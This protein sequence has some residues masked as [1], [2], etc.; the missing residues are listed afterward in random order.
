MDIYR[1]C[2]ESS[3]PTIWDWSNEKVSSTILNNKYQDQPAKPQ[4]D[5]GFRCL[6]LP[7]NT[8]SHDAARLDYTKKKNKQFVRPKEGS[9]THFETMMA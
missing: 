6:H 5:Q 8:F 7:W 4:S 9:L 2:L 3:S 1:V